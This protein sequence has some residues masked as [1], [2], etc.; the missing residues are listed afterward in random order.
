MTSRQQLLDAMNDMR[1]QIVSAVESMPLDRWNKNVYE[2][3]WNERELL[4]HIAN[5]TGPASFA[6]MMSKIP[7]RPDG[8]G[9]TFDQ[10]AF[11]A[12]QVAM[13]KDKS[14]QELLDE[15]RSNVQRDIQ[16]VEAASDEDLQREWT[17]P[18]G[19]HGSVAD[20]IVGSITGHVGAHL[21]DLRDAAK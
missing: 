11:N 3:G 6:L 14:T 20:V 4:C 17:A 16:T 10:D 18:W 13:R 15:V 5:M 12:G 2:N 21:N 9:P 19:V 7:P 8:G 1:D